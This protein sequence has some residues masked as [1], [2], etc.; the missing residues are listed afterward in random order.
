MDYRNNDTNQIIMKINDNRYLS[1]I[2]DNMN[3]GLV[4]IAMMDSN[5]EYIDD[6]TFNGGCMICLNT[7]ELAIELLKL[8]L[9]NCYNYNKENDELIEDTLNDR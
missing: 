5:K 2:E 4:E 1:I 7:Q 8:N 3:D 6:G 9:D